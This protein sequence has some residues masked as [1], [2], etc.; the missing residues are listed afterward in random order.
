MRKL[1]FML[2]I[3]FIAVGCGAQRQVVS[4]TSENQESSVYKRQDIVNAVKNGTF[5]I[6]FIEEISGRGV[7]KYAF[8]SYLIMDGN[9]IEMRIDPEFAKRRLMEFL[10]RKYQDSKIYDLVIRKK[11]MTFSMTGNSVTESIFTKQGE[12][13]YIHVSGWTNTDSCIVSVGLLE[14]A[15]SYRFRGRIKPL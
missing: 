14:G 4:R 12:N 3:A 15:V 8:D 7:S 2:C 1:Y 5:R 13:I 9:Y 11:K 6:E 10:Y